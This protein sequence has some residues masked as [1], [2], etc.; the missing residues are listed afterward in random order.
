MANPRYGLAE[1]LDRDTLIEMYRQMYLL[2]RFEERSA[3]Q[4]GLQK[5]G[6]FCHLYIGQ[7]AVAVGTEAALNDDDYVI[8]AY[9]DHGQI[10]ARGT[11][12]G[13]VM[14]ELFGKATGVAGGKGGSMHLF[15]IPRHFYGGWGI[16]GA[17][18]P[19]ALG[20]AFA[21]HYRD[22]KR[23][24]VCYFGEA[25]VNQGAF[26]EALNMA[27]LWKV[28]AIFICE[29]NRYGMGTPIKVSSAEVEVWKRGSAHNIPG[30]PVDGMDALAMYDAVK[31]AADRARAGEGPTLLEARTYRFRGH[32]MSDP[33]VYRTRDEV[34]TERK[35]DPIP[36]LRDYMTK[37]KL[38]KDADFTAIEEQV[39]KDVDGSVK[40]ADESPW[41]EPSQLYADIYVDPIRRGESK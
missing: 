26:H 24:T 34:E 7:E 39:E 11:P 15:D 8:T 6:G 13:P 10:L 33:A 31:R 22:D 32:S 1:K 25:A 27:A 38:A 37:K 36:K 29:N 18:I 4:Y 12:P 21:S 19:L 40:F 16:V 2:R 14:A 17:Q 5:I 20:T 9:R 41:P 30:E 23:V 35:N 3:Q 28:P